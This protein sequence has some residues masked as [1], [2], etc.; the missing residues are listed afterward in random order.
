M[1]SFFLQRLNDFPIQRPEDTI[2]FIDELLARPPF[3][4]TVGVLSRPESF[5]SSP[6]M[7]SR[8]WLSCV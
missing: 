5:F 8:V 2:A 6:T 7:P 4:A 3:M 1:H